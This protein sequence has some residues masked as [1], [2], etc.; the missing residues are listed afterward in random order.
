MTRGTGVLNRIVIFNKERHMNVLMVAL[1]SQ[2]DVNPFIKIGIGLRQRGHSVTLLSNTHFK[3]SVQGAGLKFVSVGSA[4]DFKKMVDEIDTDNPA[5]T[6]KAIMTHLYF[7]CM[8]TVYDRIKALSTP[9]DTVIMGI[10]LAFGARM[11]REKLGIPLITC[12]LAPVSIPSISYPPKFHGIWMPHWMPYLY[13]KGIRQ[14]IDMGADRFLGPPINTLRKELDLPPVRN[15]MNH[16]IHS[17]DK[18]IGLFP[19]W[20]AAP[21]DDWPGNTEVTNFILFDEADSKPI[22]P[23]LKRFIDAGDPPVVFTTGTAVNDADTFFKASVEVCDILNVRGVFVSRYKSNIPDRLSPYIHCCGYAP[24]SRLFPCASA[25]VHH[26][27]IGT[28][29]QALS[30][31]VPQLI[32]P[33]G[34]DQ[35]DNASRITRLGLGG[36]LPRKKY[37]NVMAANKL[38][39]LLADETLHLRCK[40]MADEFKDI[41]PVFQLSRIIEEVAENRASTRNS[42]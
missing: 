3:A 22:P 27:G 41:D 20:F 5:K 36:W 35:P 26:G 15:I 4:E 13:K 30:A 17:P 10:T 14:F 38:K 2:G 31:G 18:V 21:R 6:V 29:A 12:H 24:F 7:P 11:A 42:G 34:L 28:C 33:F 37:N 23:G 9:G 8:Q 25:V 40:R 39:T 1:G 16:W 32:I 19:E